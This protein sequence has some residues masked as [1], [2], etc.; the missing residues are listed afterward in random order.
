MYDIWNDYAK[1]NRYVLNTNHIVTGVEVWKTGK[2]K[3]IPVN[4]LVRLF[5]FILPKAAIQTEED[6]RHWIDRYQND[7]KY[8][9]VFNYLMH[10]QA[11]FD[12]NSGMLVQD[13]FAQVIEKQIFAGTFG[14]DITVTYEACEDKARYWILITYADY[15]LS[16][17]R[18]NLFEQF[19]E[20]YFKEINIYY[21]KST[22]R[23]YIYIHR[24]KTEALESIIQLAEF[25][26]CDWKRDIEIMWKGEHLPF[27]GYDYSMVLGNMY[28]G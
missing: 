9:D 18:K 25:F 2:G 21:Q 8:Q 14:S 11:T 6:Y 22:E 10:V 17:N 24:E 5:D 19:L 26:L 3:E 15:L 4:V 27:L 16:R 13:I 23:T 28:L 20:T 12:L 7:A 1:E